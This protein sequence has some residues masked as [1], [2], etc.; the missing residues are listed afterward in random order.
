MQPSP[1]TMK[2]QLYHANVKDASIAIGSKT[3]IQHLKTLNKYINAKK[4]HST[5]IL[6]NHGIIKSISYMKIQTKQGTNPT[7]SPHHCHKLPLYHVSNLSITSW[8]K[9]PC[10]NNENQPRDQTIKELKVHIMSSS[11]ETK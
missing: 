4:S 9:N 10:F 11:K 8:W 5:M 1:Y 7:L 2:N 6:S 3:N